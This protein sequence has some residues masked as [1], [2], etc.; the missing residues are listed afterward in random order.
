[1]FMN[2]GVDFKAFVLYS[3]FAFL[4]IIATIFF[5]M[6]LNSCTPETTAMFNRDKAEI[7]QQIHKQAARDLHEI[8]DTIETKKEPN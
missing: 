1:M 3:L 8:A 6:M 5:C 2:D 7:N 4:V